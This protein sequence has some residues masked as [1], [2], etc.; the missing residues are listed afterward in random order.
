M[1][2]PYAELGVPRDATQEQIKAAHRRKVK[3]L[4]P[5][6]GGGHE[7]FQR[8]QAAYDTLKDPKAREHYDRTGEGQKATGPDEALMHLATIFQGLIVE[9]LSEG[10]DSE[11]SDIGDMAKGAMDKKLAEVTAER[12]G[13]ERALKRAETLAK[14][15]KRKRKAKGFDF[16]GDTLR[17]GQR[18]IQEQIAKL[19]QAEEV[20][21]RARKILD[22]YNYDFDENKGWPDP[23]T[24]PSWFG[25]GTFHVEF[26][27]TR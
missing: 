10:L 14:R 18:D 25:P 9:L 7:E 27:S 1:F 15:W 2:D 8:V 20:W 4:H 19:K 5:D 23:A 21:K 17:R 24:A 13:K 11:S 6:A 3:T 22:Q 16:I 12:E 26:T